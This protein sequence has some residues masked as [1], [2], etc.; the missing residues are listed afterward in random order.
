MDINLIAMLP[1]WMKTDWMG[2]PVWMWMNF[3]I[4]IVSILAYDLGLFSK[5]KD[6][7]PSVKRSLINTLIYIS[8]AVLFGWDTWTDLGAKAGM[9]FFTGYAMEL[10]L[11]IDN[12]F[13]ISLIFSSLGI[14][15]QYRHRVLFWG[16]LGVL[17]LRGIMIGAGAALISQ[18]SWILLIFGIFLLFT[19]FKMLFVQNEHS[20]IAD[21]PALKWMQKHLP[22]TK[23]LH[24]ERFFVRLPN[25][26]NPSR[27]MTFITPLFVALVLVEIAD[28]VF[29][30]DSVPAVFAVTQD[31]Y[32]VYTSNIFAIIGLRSLFFLL[33]DMVHRFEYLSKALAFI[34]IFIG[35]KITAAE[36]LHYHM[37]TEISLSVVLTLIFSGIAISL[38]KTRKK[39]K[40]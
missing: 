37:P 6:G 23:E 7:P 1:E 35:G 15:A 27:N 33:E 14:P 9:E 21:N 36:L 34:L 13:V 4:T 22:I 3:L 10:S 17:I 16:I 18:F 24:K 39:D 2:H 11:S 5:K 25:P 12:I 40:A 31:P 38:L 32:I 20:E 29:A 30:V 19:G 28:L 8:L 26:Q